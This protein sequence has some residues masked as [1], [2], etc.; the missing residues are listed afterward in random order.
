MLENMTPPKS[1]ALSCK[2]DL[3]AKEMTDADREIFLNAVADA[4]LWA[5]NTLSRE[6]AKRG[7]SVADVTIARHRQQLCNC[8]R[9]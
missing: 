8:F 3:L 1:K 5:A 6:L 7:V 2:I 4:D 9:D